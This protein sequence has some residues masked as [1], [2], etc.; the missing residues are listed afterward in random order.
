MSIA[1]ALVSGYV[2]HN[3]D[4]KKLNKDEIEQF[5][6]EVD[7]LGFQVTKQETTYKFTIAKRTD[8]SHTLKRAEG[9]VI[10]E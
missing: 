3:V 10:P 8:F 6:A 5:W 2:E 9:P 1:K 7:R 4:L